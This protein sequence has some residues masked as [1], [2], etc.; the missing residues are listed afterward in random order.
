MKIIEPGHVYELDYLNS[1]GGLAH[2]KETSY[3]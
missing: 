2:M 3:E 1:P